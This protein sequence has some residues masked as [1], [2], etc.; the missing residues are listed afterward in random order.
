VLGGKDGGEAKL[1]QSSFP[2]GVETAFAPGKG[3]KKGEGILRSGR[4]E[5][6]HL[7]TIRGVFSEREPRHEGRRGRKEKK[8]W[9]SFGGKLLKKD[10]SRACPF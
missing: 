10:S 9:R 6:L 3:G 2:V 1:S 8:S 5:T 4:R 7:S